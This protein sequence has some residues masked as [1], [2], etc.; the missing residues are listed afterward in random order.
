MGPAGSGRTTPATSVVAYSPATSSKLGLLLV[1]S[2]PCGP[3][4]PFGGELD[5]IPEVRRLLPLGEQVEHPLQGG[6]ARLSGS[7]LGARGARYAIGDSEH[8]IAGRL[9]HRRT[10]SVLARL[11]VIAVFGPRME[12]TRM[13]RNGVDHPSHSVSGNSWAS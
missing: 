10:G 11:L 9:V 7:E 2:P 4:Q 13:D 6:P 12:A 8:N 5:D 3:A 1:Q